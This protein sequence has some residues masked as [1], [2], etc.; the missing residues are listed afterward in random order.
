MIHLR[1]LIKWGTEPGLGAQLLTL[2]MR[3]LRCSA[4]L[5]PLFESR[6]K[7]NEIRTKVSFLSKGVM[8]ESLGVR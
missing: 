4:C 8:E 5:L 6:E 3:L 2:V 7:A 1:L